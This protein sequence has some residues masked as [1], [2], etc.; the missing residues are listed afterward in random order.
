[1]AAEQQA[2]HALAE[3]PFWLLLLI[4]LSGIAGEMR[5][6]DLAGVALGEI[7][8]RILLRWGSSAL[9][10]F[11]ALF[12]AYAMWGDVYVAGGLAIG[13]GLLGADVAGALYTKWLAGRA[14]VEPPQGAGR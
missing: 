2:Q 3:L 5:R 6:A 9:F 1:M 10:G 12:L 4:A 14:G 11:A 7:V 13:I 8:Q